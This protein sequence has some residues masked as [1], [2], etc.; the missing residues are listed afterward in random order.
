MM[1][2]S[3]K[4]RTD[5]AIA[6]AIERRWEEAAAENR[7]LL[8]DFPDDLEAANRLGKALTETGDLAG[9]AAAYGRSMEIDPANMI[10][11]RNLSRIEEL[12]G[13]E[14][15]AG[16]RK[17][18]RS[19]RATPSISPAA[20]AA[21]NAAS[22]PYSLIEESGRSVE[23]TLIE[24]DMA[25]LEHVSAG[26]PATLTPTPRGVAVQSMEGVALGQIEARAALRL[27][28]LMAGGNQYAVLIRRVAEDGVTVYVRETHRAPELADEPSFLPPAA[29]I[30][31]T[32]TRAYTKTSV[33]R[34]ET[35]G[36][37]NDDD[38]TDTDTDS[39]EPRSRSD[40]DDD[41]M[42]GFGDATLQ[43]DDDDD[44]DD[45]DEPLAADDDE[46]DDS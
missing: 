41:E 7:S 22:R 25:T 38:D 34:Y 21:A 37:P 3:R 26:D 4:Q 32:A 8:T 45:D 10:A 35:G 30:R 18:A 44:D 39:W 16:G 29:A 9:A 31:R 17:T 15:A 14:K 33:L 1:K 40:D 13:Q 23:F 11:R 42:D 36:G 27:R 46:D 28:R 2:R 20:A 19:R 5:S 43:D 6:Y 24:P 12:R